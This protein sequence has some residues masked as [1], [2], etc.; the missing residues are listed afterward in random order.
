MKEGSRPAVK[1]LR[2]VRTGETESFRQLGP[3]EVSGGTVEL[4]LAPNSLLT[5]TTC[6]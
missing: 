3:V 6:R 5:L 1:E 4:E 2:A